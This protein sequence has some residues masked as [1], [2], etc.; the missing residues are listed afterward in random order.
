MARNSLTIPASRLALLARPDINASLTGILRGLEKESLRVTPTGELAQTDHPPELGSA[1]KHPHITTDYSEALLEF[2]TEPFNRIDDL[3]QQLDDIHR[4]T[5]DRLAASGERLWP[6]SMPCKLGSDENIPVAR[7]GSSNSGRMKTVYRV[8]LGH[9]YGRAMQT[10]AGVHYNFSLPDSFWEPLH[11]QE[12]GS[13]SLTDFKTRK[14][15]ALIRNFR[16]YF[17]LMIYLFGA[18]P[19]VC[20]SFVQGR[21][22]RLQP[23]PHHPGTMYLPYATSLR[24]GDLGYQSSAQQAL[25][26]NYN[27]LP[28]Y[29]DTLCGAITRT[30]PDYE[31]IGLQDAGGNYRQLNTGLLQIENE[32]YSSIRP[33][34]TARSGETALQALRLGGVE[35]I[36][37]R[38]LDLNPYEPLGV[39]AEQLQVMDAF[40]LFC[41][42]LDSPD[43]DAGAWHEEQ[44]NQKNIVYYG[45]DPQLQLQHQGETSAMG[46]W[47]EEILQQTLACARI[48]DQA[49]GGNAYAAA[50]EAQ[51]AK[52]GDPSLTPSARL[53]TEIESGQGSFF[54]HT[55]ALAEEHRRW[56][57]TR[58]PDAD[59]KARFEALRDTSLQA[60][61]EQEAEPEPPFEAY[62][63][64][65]YQQYRQCRGCNTA[66][67]IA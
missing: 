32:F 54:R 22:H 8:G 12:G 61:Q 37:V 64:D 56:F 26:V 13:E 55:L 6:A 5:F 16:R 52:L 17:W 25:V 19:A 38:C 11:R 43:T 21:Q 2:I 66:A 33:K 14:Y 3:L 50:V 27:D 59:I 48:L 67:D 10:I 36:E 40:L 1:L 35:Y 20:S 45:R 18:A 9:R 47:A 44:Q 34:R 30:H 41:L 58:Q 31:A 29:L 60:Q 65:W 57:A 49:H 62:L 42:L 15:F 28:G 51:F 23:M 24:M 46:T 7:Y 4:F 63:A 39:S 53:L